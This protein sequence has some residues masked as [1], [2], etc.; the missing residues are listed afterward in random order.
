MCSTCTTVSTRSIT[1]EGG[2]RS[3]HYWHNYHYHTI[4]YWSVA[5]TLTRILQ[6]CRLGVEMATTVLLSCSHPGE[7]SG[8]HCEQKECLTET[9][10]ISKFF[11]YLYGPVWYILYTRLPLLHKILILNLLSSIITVSLRSTR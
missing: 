8:P 3:T 1:H 4:S 7:G 5:S 11:V 9:T 2:S 6:F 10:T